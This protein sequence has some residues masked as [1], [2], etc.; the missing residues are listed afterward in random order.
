MAMTLGSLLDELRS[1]ILHDKSDQVAG[2]SSDYLWDDT[3]L[4]RY[5]NEAQR[6]FA[7]RSL[8]IRDNTTTAVSQF[9]TV[10]GQSVYTLDPS[11]IAVLSV[12]MT[13]DTQDIPRA[14]HAAF[15]TYSN[16]DPYYFDASQLETIPPGKPLAWSSDDNITADANGSF[17]VVNLT[18]F[19][20]VAA[21]YNGI[22]GQMRVI[23]EPINDLSLKNLKA[24]P[25]IPAAHHLDMLDWAAYLALRNVDTDVAGAGAAQRAADFAARFEAHCMDLRK[26]TMRKLFTPLQWGFGRNGWS[27]ET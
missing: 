8:C 6:R 23:R 10:T 22:V 5:I 15:N 20:V 18:L 1:N 3:T 16:P 7:R 25:E 11:V 9:T 17:S 2:S 4:V 12:R 24:Y 14:G 27:W 19:P 13:G 26:E 21:P